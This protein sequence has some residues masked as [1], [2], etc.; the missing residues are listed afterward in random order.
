MSPGQRVRTAGSVIVRQRPGT[1][2]GMLFI[3][4]EDET[5]MS[6]AIVGPDLLRRERSTIVGTAGLIVEGILE[7]RDGAVSVKAEK[8]W[9]L[10]RLARTPSHDFH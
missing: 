3:T 10:D 6:Q 7:S 4:L 8:F 2:K 9:S 1:A 5:G